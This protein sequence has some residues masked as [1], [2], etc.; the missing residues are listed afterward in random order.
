V[1]RTGKARD[2]RKL[3]HEQD[4]DER[5]EAGNRLQASHTRIAGPAPGE[6]LVRTA[7]LGVQESEQ[8][9]R[10]IADRP[11]RRVEAQLREFTLASD[12]Q[13]ARGATRLEIPPCEQG[14][15]GLVPSGQQSYHPS[16]REEIR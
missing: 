4:G 13:P 11:G 3:E 9:Q 1:L 2:V 7:D 12:A 5:P 16:H 8:G 6:L 15:P 14:I 10:V